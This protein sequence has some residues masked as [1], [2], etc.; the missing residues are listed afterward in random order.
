MLDTQ[1]KQQLAVM[2]RTAQIIVG[3]LVMGVLTFGVVVV[4][5]LAG[6]GGAQGN[7]LTLLAVGFAAAALV[8]CLLVPNLFASAQRRKIA[9]GT[10]GST[11]APGPAPDSDAGKLAMLYQTKLIIGAA[12]LEGG[13]FLGL[14]AYMLE[15]QWPSLAMAGVLLLALIA[16]LPTYGRVEAWIED[17]LRR[18][19]EDRRF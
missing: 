16:H 11:S 12:M 18:V 19:Q 7:T 2:V 17:Q 1:A 4:S 13:C 6:G 10:W 3:A 8:L 5:G 9:A 14:V 15:R